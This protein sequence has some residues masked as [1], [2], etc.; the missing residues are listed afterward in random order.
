MITTKA[1]PQRPVTH[2][3]GCYCPRC[4]RTYTTS[5]VPLPALCPWC[6][7][8]GSTAFDMPMGFG[9]VTS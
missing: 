4:N 3:Y 7:K 1:P 8:G 9:W 6:E 5:Q 2:E